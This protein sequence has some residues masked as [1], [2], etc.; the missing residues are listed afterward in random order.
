MTE[1]KWLDCTDP[2]GMLESFRR[3]KTGV[4]NLARFNA[5][6]ASPRKL[7]LFATACYRR[8][9]HLLPLEHNRLAVE[10][11]ELLAEGHAS[12]GDVFSLCVAT[13]AD[14]TFDSQLGSSCL[15][16]DAFAAAQRS[17]SDA[18]ATIVRA[19]NLKEG[20]RELVSQADLLR[21][22]F[23]NP[24][25]PVSTLESS[26]LTR[27]DEAVLNL[28]RSAYNERYLPAGTLDNAKL[29]AL[30]DA[31]KEAGCNDAEL[32]GHLRSEGP[33]VRGCW[34]LDA[35]LGKS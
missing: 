11:G 23:G 33:H 30:A 32:L 12:Q 28:A 1:A 17:S 25:R 6:D 5:V 4:P 15:F 21:E 13:S 16:P 14:N 10:S 2:N 20:R 8:V 31:L 35:V 24:F 27:N 19:F 34:A 26:L 3:R 9:W 22:I 18:A 29:A 7:R